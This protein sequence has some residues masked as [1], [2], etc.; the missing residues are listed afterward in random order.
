MS[1]LFSQGKGAQ[2]FEKFVYDKFGGSLTT[3]DSVDDYAYR[4]NT[5]RFFGTANFAE[6]VVGS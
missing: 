1:Q 3:S 5:P 2:A 4:F 6:Y